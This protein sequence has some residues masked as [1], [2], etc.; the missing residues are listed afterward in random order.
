M[1]VLLKGPRNGPLLRWPFF[2]SVCSQRACG[3]PLRK[4][5][6]SPRLQRLHVVS[7]LEVL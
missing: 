5:A 3:L 2:V 6:L 4:R 1:P 7:V